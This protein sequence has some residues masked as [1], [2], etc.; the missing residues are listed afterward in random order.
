MDNRSNNKKNNKNNK[1]NKNFNYENITNKIIRNP[2]LSL[3]EKGL[4]WDLLQYWNINQECFPS[5]TT[6][7]GNHGISERQVRRIL[8]GI[9]NKGFVFQVVRRGYSLSN[10]YT[11]NELFF[12]DE[13]KEMTYQYGNNYPIHKGH[14]LPTN[15]YINNIKGNDVYPDIYDLYEEKSNR[16]LNSNNRVELDTLLEKY[17][18]ELLKS[19]ITKASSQ[20]TSFNIEYLRKILSDNRPLAKE[21]PLFTP[22]GLNGCD[23][24][25]IFDIKE[26]E[27]RDC[28]CLAKYKLM[29]KEKGYNEKH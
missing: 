4:I 23:G 3:R 17:G 14:N 13:R 12:R 2:R 7:A 18:V 11:F 19:A 29:L 16:R 28:A 1:N 10:L 26:N 22:C 24:G 27:V 15:N 6:L 25:H 20:T 5:Q 21:K 9:A 8:S